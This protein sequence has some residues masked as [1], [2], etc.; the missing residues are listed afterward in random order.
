MQVQS[1]IIV[2]EMGA[3]IAVLAIYLLVLLAP[4]H[5]VSA[6]QHDL[7]ELG[8]ASTATVDICGS[9]HAEGDDRSAG[10]TCHV[11]GIDKFEFAAILPPAPSFIAPRVVKGTL[12]PAEPVF[13]SA[14]HATR[15]GEARAPPLR[16]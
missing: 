1:R 16:A 2:R 13:A 3:A 9:G 12:R 11:A 10:F 7:A 6:L 15:V 4:W 8:Y 14:A 5:Q